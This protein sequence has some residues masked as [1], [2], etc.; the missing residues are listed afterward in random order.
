[1]LTIVKELPEHVE[2]S[3]HLREGTP[4]YIKVTHFGVPY[5]IAGTTNVRQLLELDKNGKQGQ[6]DRRL[7][8][9]EYQKADALRDIVSSLH[10]QVRDVALAGV[11][12]RVTTTLLDRMERALA[13]TVRRAVEG[14][15]RKAL[16]PPE[17]QSAENT[18]F[19]G[20]EKS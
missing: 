13:P 11:E 18:A 10:L 9:G 1:M 19:R 20:V 8:W 14:E 15:A 16:P 3:Q 7:R 5:Y 12:E 2:L 6:R 4:F 17:R